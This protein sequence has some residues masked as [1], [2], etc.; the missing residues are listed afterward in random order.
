MM[1]RVSELEEQGLTVT[2][3]RALEP[4]FGDPSWRL[5]A[6]SLQ[7][8]AD[9]ADVLVQ[10][11]LA[12]TVPQTCGRCLE[13]FPARVDATVDVRL[14]PRPATK[15]NVELGADDLDVDFYDND[16]LDVTRVVANEATLALPMKALCRED[17]RGL[18]PVCGANRNVAPCTCDTRPPDPRLVAL[19]DLASRL[20]N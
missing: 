7:I 5:E 10:G 20:A 9:G 18:C 2:D 12:A 16:E 17:C 4:A 3:P 6:L 19:R 14:V 15:D 8:S 13:S 11:R 1:I